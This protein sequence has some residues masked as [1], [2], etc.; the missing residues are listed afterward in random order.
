[1]AHCPKKD[2]EI[3]LLYRRSLE[4]REN[5]RKMG[6]DVELV[7]EE[8]DDD[9]NVNGSPLATSYV[10]ED[11]TLQSADRFLSMCISKLVSMNS[12]DLFSSIGSGARTR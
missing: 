10:F 4:A 12:S 8:V 9:N 3:L 7:E 1:M 11:Q 6:I 2:V 5:C